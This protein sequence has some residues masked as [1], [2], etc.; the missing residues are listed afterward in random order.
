[1]LFFMIILWNFIFTYD[2]YLMI[3]RPDVYN[4]DNMFY[5]RAFVYFTGV[6][7]SIV[8]FFP[9]M[10]IFT[11]SVI[12]ICYIKTGLIY[13]IFVNPPFEEVKLS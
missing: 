12:Y 4:Q 3:R 10:E 6:M 13:N 1:M 8:V 9:N 2:V 11:E 5:F 7:F